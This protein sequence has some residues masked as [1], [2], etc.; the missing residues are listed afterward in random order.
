MPYNFEATTDFS[1]GVREIDS[2]LKYS[3]DNPEDQILFL[4]MS[5]ISLVTKFQVFV[6]KILEEYKFKLKGKPCTILPVYSRINSVR[7]AMKNSYLNKLD[8]NRNYDLECKN[9]IDKELKAF[10]YLKDDSLIEDDFL[11]DGKFPLGRTGK[12]ELISLFRQIQGDDNPFSAFDS[13]EFQFDKLDSV[14]QKRHLVI[15]QDRFNGSK[16]DIEKD[17][18]FVKKLSEYIDDYLKIET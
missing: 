14:L 13:E 8:N 1:N 9:K 16:N 10:S 15:H 7:L 12:K 18:Q 6:E 17:V 3:Q 4:K 2:L 11:I 5:V